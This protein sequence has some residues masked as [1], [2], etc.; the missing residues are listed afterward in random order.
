MRAIPAEP[1]PV[2]DGAPTT[3]ERPSRSRLA[4]A[5]SPVAR[6]HAVSGAVIELHADELRPGSLAAAFGG[7]AAAAIVRFDRRLRNLWAHLIENPD[8]QLPWQATLI[9]IARN[10]VGSGDITKS[11]GDGI[12]I[13]P[14]LHGYVSRKIEIERSGGQTRA[15]PAAF[16]QGAGTYVVPR[17]ALDECCAITD[18]LTAAL[19]PA[20]HDLPTYRVAVQRL[21]YQANPAECDQLAE[22]ICDA[23]AR[24]GRTGFRIDGNRARLNPRLGNKGLTDALALTM[25]TRLGRQLAGWI[26]RIAGD[27]RLAPPSGPNARIVEREHLDER[28]F[29]ALCGR[30]DSVCTQIFTDGAWCD[31]PVDLDSLAV[32]PGKLAERAFGLRPTLHRV[33]YTGVETPEPIDP[34][35]GNVTM[36]LGAV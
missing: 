31:L 27:P 22:V 6:T 20:H 34:Q 30:R 1:V 4:R 10:H 7:G 9:D 32:F 13:Q 3:S 8:E 36:L 25:L 24:W 35:S 14:G 18:R 11:L 23:L 26:D 33:I 17:A 21:K 2:V 28:F 12:Y 5:A 15:T 19:T 29:S 16:A